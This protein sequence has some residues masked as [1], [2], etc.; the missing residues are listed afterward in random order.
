MPL[1]HV[2]HRVFTK[3]VRMSKTGL[4]IGV[5]WETQGSYIQTYFQE[6]V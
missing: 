4:A 2:L 1:I 5:K 3:N 6:P